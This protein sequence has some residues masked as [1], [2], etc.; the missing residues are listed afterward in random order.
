MGAFE[1]MLQGRLVHALFDAVYYPVCVCTMTISSLHTHGNHQI[2]PVFTNGRMPVRWVIRWMTFGNL[3][4][5]IQ[6]NIVGRN[7]AFP[8][9]I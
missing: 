4:Y 2:K 7:T 1:T 5:K 6:Q 3:V 8:W 9:Y